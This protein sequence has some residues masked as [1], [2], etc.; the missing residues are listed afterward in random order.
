MYW[1][2]TPFNLIA[3]TEYLRTCGMQVRSRL[4]NDMDI[5]PARMAR[6]CSVCKE[7][8]HTKARCPTRF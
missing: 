7:T 1:P 3:N 4:K 5:A 8:G 2:P 6:K